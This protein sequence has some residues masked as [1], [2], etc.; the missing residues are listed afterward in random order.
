MPAGSVLKS[1]E[2]NG[3]DIIDN[4]EAGVEAGKTYFGLWINTAP[5][6]SN[7]LKI[8]YELPTNVTA[9]KYNLT[10]QKQPGNLGDELKVT[11][12]NE[13]L[14]SGTLNEDDLIK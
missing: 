14:F 13:V 1:A 9:N 10:I 12:V 3:K 6:T 4:V 8:S 2:L 11:K 7:V 5:Q